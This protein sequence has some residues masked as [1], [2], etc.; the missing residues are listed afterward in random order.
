MKLVRLLPLIFVLACEAPVEPTPEATVPADVHSYSRP[1]E[2]AVTHLALDVTVDFESRSIAGTASLT[3][4]HNAPAEQLW[5]DARG[6]TIEE[7]MLDDGVPTEWRLGEER[8][9]MG[10]PLA[11]DIAPTTQIVHI[12]YASSPDAAALQWLAP[13]QTAGKQ[14]PFLLSQSQSILART[15]IPCQD[16]PGVRMTY[17]AVVRV[18]A[19]LMALMSAENPTEKSSNGIYRFEMTQPIPAYLLAIAVG[20]VEFRALGPKSG[21]YAEPSVVEA[22]AWEFADTPEMIEIAEELYGPYRW[23]RYDIIVLP[24]SFPFGG[25]E[26]PRLTF[27][28]P[29]ILAGDRS[30]VA[31]IAHELAHSWSG[32]LVTNATWNDFWL[33]EGFTVY[34]ERRIMEAL[35]GRDY[36]EMLALLG[37]Q[38]LE[39]TIEELGADHPDTHLYL[40]LAGRD[41]DEG[42]TDVAYEKGALL[43]RTLEEHVGRERFDAFLR[44]Y[45]ERY[46]FR[47]MTT[48]DFVDY[49]SKQLFDGE[50][51]AELQLDAWIHGPG[52]PD[53]RPEI[54]SAAF[55]QV[56]AQLESWKNGSDPS[57]LETEGWTSHQWLHFVRGLPEERLAEL[58]E[59][60]GFSDTGN[61]EVLAAWLLLA[62]RAE[63]EPA[64]PA[65]ERF[66]T[67]MGRRKFLRPLYTALAATPEGSERARAIYERARAG[68]HPVSTGTIDPIVGWPSS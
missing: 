9:F 51:P 6:L 59:T 50:A 67:G 31:L 63:Y 33:N 35:A 57:S 7:V 25:M 55:E 61:S 49:L 48:A 41:P 12:R 60:F 45:F 54:V 46:A 11:I 18:P 64:Y 3:L 29:T 24:P 5:L 28:T 26:N 17:E 2:V 58:D 16:S 65:L 39:R 36:S 15:W 8:P 42:L 30:L 34:F 53:N 10:Q 38:D 47:T 4:E 52:I 13:Q 37:E 14:A 56:D 43:L 1:H 66:L 22:A 20:D 44:E 32:N 62:I 27:A 21:V 40:D 68:Y 19:G 23:E